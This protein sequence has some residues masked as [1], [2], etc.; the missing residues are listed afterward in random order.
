MSIIR[1]FTLYLHAGISVPPVVHVNQYDQGEVWRFT[2]LEEDGS[3]YTPSS[4]ALIGVKSDGHAI[5]GVTGTVMGD[6]RVSITETQQMTAAAG[7]AV[8]ELTIDGG[9][10]GTANFIVQVE[11]K[12]T[13]SAILSDSDLS[14]IQEGLNSVTPVVIAET[15]SDW[16]EDN[17]TDPPID[18][19][20][21]I[22][23]AAADAKVTGDKLTELKTELNKVYYTKTVSGAQYHSEAFYYPLAIGDRFRVRNIGTASVNVR[24]RETATGSNLFAF[25]VTAGKTVEFSSTVNSNYVQI[26]LADAGGAVFEGLTEKVPVLEKNISTLNDAN[27]YTDINTAELWESGGLAFSSGISVTSSI[28]IRTADYISDDV[29]LIVCKPAYSVGVY[30]YSNGTYI[31]LYDGSIFQKSSFTTVTS[32]N[33]AKL[34]ESYGYYFKLV[35]VKQT[36]LD[37]SVAESEN[38]ELF[39]N[40]FA[41]VSDKSYGVKNYTLS[42]FRG[43]YIIDDTIGQTVDITTTNILVGGNF[44]SLV[45]KCLAGDKFVLTSQGGVSAR[46]W[47]FADENLILVQTS[48][49]GRYEDIEVKAPAD[50]WFIFNSTLEVDYKVLY[51]G[52]VIADELMGDVDDN[53][54]GIAELK[55]Y[56]PFVPENAPSTAPVVTSAEYNSATEMTLSEI[57][58]G[59]ESLLSAYSG[60]ITKTTLGND[61]SGTYPIYRYD[62]VPEMPLISHAV[63]AADG[64]KY[65]QD[66]MPVIILEACLHGSEKPCARALL[67]LM[68][69]ICSAKSDN[70]VFGWFRRNFHFVVIPVVNPWGYVNTTRWN[71]NHV[72]INRNFPIYWEN[73]SDDPTDMHY[74]GTSAGSEAETQYVMEIVDEYAGKAILFYDYH[75]YGVRDIYRNQ[76]DFEI[77]FYKTNLFQQVGL[78]T[79]WDIT[80]SGWNNH[81]LPTNSGFIGFV[82]VYTG[83]R[84]GMAMNYGAYKRIPSA[85]P[86]CMYRYND[87]TSTDTDY[88]PKI[89]YMNIEYM[90]F[91]ILNA[92]NK[93][94][95]HGW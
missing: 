63:T 92:L 64:K 19:T 39:K 82:Q 91:T 14:I 22:S 74:R 77:S 37:I 25:T 66:D 36:D 73:G 26:Y 6:G 50:G 23:N 10:H 32:V 93:L 67:N 44:V 2:L 70:D 45:K 31:G 5:A 80:R 40:P 43:G 95:E 12:P 57:Y 15:V 47:A 87:G 71:S 16:L 46:S 81:E 85:T 55:N 49:I 75:T 65:T 24:Q 21:S 34:K 51:T 8:F 94:I 7:K 86:E 58:N 11:P 13:D 60:Y 83:E 53:R 52:N 18:P 9:S 38:V 29:S 41:N 79:I 69:K 59:Y 54:E 76:T 30:A 68:D 42:N 48:G 35:L 1:D 17:L 78:A 90:M 88:S 3:K 33:L 27:G 62:F 20:L 4:G 89:N 72:D 84:V 28:R 56:L 61:E